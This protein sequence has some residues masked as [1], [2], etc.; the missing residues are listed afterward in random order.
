MTH[1]TL[2]RFLASVYPQVT[3][4]LER[5]RAGVGAVR[6]LVRTLAS[7]GPH[8]TLELAQLD[9]GVVALGALV[10]LL[11]RVPVADVARQLARGRE[12]RL[13]VAALVRLGARVGVDVV[14]QRRQR[15][16]PA[17]AHRTPFQYQTTNFQDL[18]KFNSIRE[19]KLLEAEV[20]RLLLTG[21]SLNEVQFST[22][23]RKSSSSSTKNC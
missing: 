23:K 3:L 19:K 11:E 8:V 6:A 9:R 12:R 18:D 17:L 10:R 2:V 15:L 13:A 21:K 20:Q 16:E 7:V 22:H 5:V 4:Q 1:V 14:V